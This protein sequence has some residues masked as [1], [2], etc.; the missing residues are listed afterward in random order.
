MGFYVLLAFAAVI[1]LAQPFSPAVQRIRLKQF[2]L[3]Q[4]SFGLF[5]LM[6]FVP[7]M[8]S[9]AN[10]IWYTDR[11]ADFHEIESQEDTT[12]ETL[13]YWLNHYPT[14][15][16]SFSTFGRQKFF[17]TAGR[18]YLYLRS[19][20]RDTT[21]RTVYEL[22]RDGSRLSLMLVEPGGMS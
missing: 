20:Y 11:L 15:I 7:P 12:E 14:R 4:E 5:A 18:H 10:E 13:H 6:H 21:L 19:R 3:Q 2:H 1:L 9:F 8:Y 16:V 22:R 17:D